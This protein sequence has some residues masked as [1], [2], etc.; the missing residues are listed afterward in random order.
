MKIQ[1]LKLGD[2]YP[3]YN[4]PRNNQNAVQPVIES[5]KKFGFI[6]PIM[7]DKDH[8]IICGHTRYIAA[9]QCGCEYVPVVV[10]DMPEEQAKRFRILDNKI[11]EKSS[12]DEDEL[13]EE[14]KK[15]EAPEEMQAFFFEDISRMINFSFNQFENNFNAAGGASNMTDFSYQ[16]EGSGGESIDESPAGDA[17]QQPS[18]T[19]SDEGGEE[20]EEEEYNTMGGGSEDEYEDPAKDLFVVQMR[21]DATKFMKVVC[22]YCGNIEEIDIEED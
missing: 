6:K 1:T 16:Q 19:P 4:N 14:L 15:M 3:Y 7:V 10:S 9:F 18:Y 21:P 17:Y 11:G 13:I 8:I 20:Q 22:P 12:F 5:F 2:I